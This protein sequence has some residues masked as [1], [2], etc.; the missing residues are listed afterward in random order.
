MNDTSALAR[1]VAALERERLKPLFEQRPHLQKKW[2][3]ELQFLQP[4]G[5]RNAF[6][7]HDEEKG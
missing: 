4:R 2:E 1:T 7:D 5:P 3:L 6:H